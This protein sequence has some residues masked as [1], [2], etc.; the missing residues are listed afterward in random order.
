M[1]VSTLVLRNLAYFWRTHLAVLAGVVVAVGVLTGALLVGDSVRGSLQELFLSRL[2]N[3]EI[4]VSANDFYRDALAAELG[5]ETVPL[6]AF[7]GMVTHEPSG[8]RRADVQVYGVDERFWSFHDF[9]DPGLSGRDVLVTRALGDELGSSPGDTLLLRVERPSAVARGSLHGDKDDV[10]RTIRLTLGGDDVPEFS[11]YPRQDAV[12]AIY[13]PLSRLQ[14]DLEQR[15]EVNTILV[16]GER[17]VSTVERRL[18]EAARLNDVGVQVR[19]LEGRD[20]LSVESDALM[21][22]DPVAAAV[23][24][25]ASARGMETTSIFTYLA[26]TLR[27]GDREVP[28]SLVTAIDDDV[29]RSLLGGERPMA[30]SLVLNTWAATDLEAETGDSLTMEFYVW[31]EEGQLET[32]TAE[33]VVDGVTPMEGWGADRDVAPEYPGIS[34]TDDLAD[35]QP[36]FPIDLRRI[37]DEDEA[38]W[39][40]Y[41][42]TPKA[43]IRLARG[44]RLWPVRHGSLTSIRLHTDDPARDMDAVEAG[45]SD[46]LDPLELGYRVIPVRE[47]GIEA[48]RGA[49]DFGEYFIYFSYFLVVAALLLTGLFFKLGVEQ[50]LREVGTLMAAGFPIGIIRRVFLAEGVV[51]SVVGGALG[52]GLALAYAW[53]ILY[54]LRTWWVDA[55]GTQ[56]LFLHVSGS[57]LAIGAIGGIVVASLSIALTLRHLRTLSP[58]QLLMGDARAGAPVTRARGT[59]RAR[60]VAVAAFAGAV[61]L[62]GASAA[63]VVSR[64]VGFFGAG[65]LLL[66]SLLTFHWV[67]LRSGSK[68]VVEGQ[69][70]VAMFRLGFRNAT[71]RPGRSLVAIALIAFASFTIVAVDAFRKKDE[72]VELDEQSGSGGYPLVAESLLP[73]HWDPNTLEGRDASNL[74]YP[75]DPDAVEMTIETFRLRPGDDA[76]CLN[77]YRPQ[78]PRIL[79]ADEEFVGEARFQFASS[80][81]DTPEERENPWLLLEKELLDGAIPVIGDA[82]S[83]TYVLHLGLGEDFLLSRVGESPL[84]LRLVATLAD[85]IFQSELLMSEENFLAHFPDTDGFRYFLVETPSPDEASQ[86]LEE[87]LS[88]FGL[89]VQST[90]AKLAGFHR[91]ENTYLSTFQTLGGLGLVLGTFGL[92]AVLMRNVLERR[93]ELALLRAVGYESHDF[94]TMIIAENALLLFLGLLTGGIAAVIAI[95]PALMERGGSFGGASL[96]ILLLAVV[97]SGLLSSVLAVSSVSRSPLLESLRAE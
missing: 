73:L 17:D 90:A 22:S 66:V 61:S 29:Y 15:D 70:P 47:E 51:V 64:V 67:W 4:V 74:P 94:S 62:L 89:D 88:D 55:V 60:I 52:I 1:K 25:E 78:N 82:N 50:R 14:E 48:S 9:A 68:K 6:I 59:R 42:T 63:G 41:R 16:G 95:A 30:P 76:S 53:I 13:V 11:L 85:S 7:T 8:R 20:A 75:E 2:G 34:E 19:A 23:R 80:L 33:F 69:G 79:A 38:Y 56:L 24:A 84:R 45:L 54:G 92:A 93:R 77:L 72:A 71:H 87:R 49:T 27:V 96:G 81:A 39:D 65:N 3:T 44:Q 57:S 18:R 83:M 31:R 28:Y 86:L 10:G 12:R 97:V 5:S 21:L 37:R 36:P 43:F 26:N 32:H 40:E 46:R 58:R 91:V 35:W